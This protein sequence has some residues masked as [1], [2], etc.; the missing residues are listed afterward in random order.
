MLGRT[1]RP[2]LDRRCQGVILRNEGVIDK[3]C[4]WQGGALSAYFT[5]AVLYSAPSQPVLV[6]QQGVQ[7][8]LNVQ[9]EARICM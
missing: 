8:N 1:Q 5:C 6:L 4:S 7:G 3:P 2:V 9:P